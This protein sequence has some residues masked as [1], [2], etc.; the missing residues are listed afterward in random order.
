MKTILLI[1]L[2]L[3]GIES[4][5][6]Q[7]ELLGENTWYLQKLIIE[8]T[9]YDPPLNDESSI[10]PFTLEFD[11]HELSMYVSFCKN[12]MNF[13]DL[14]FLEHNQFTVFNDVSLPMEYCFNVE[15]R[16][17]SSFHN[18]FFRDNA[19]FSFTYT[20][21]GSSQGVRRLVITDN[22]RN[23]A[24]YSNQ[25]LS[26]SQFEKAAFKIYPNP[27]SD[28]LNLEWDSSEQISPS[29]IEIYDSLGKLC[30]KQQIASDKKSVELKHFTTGLYIV[31]LLNREG[32]IL[33]SEKILVQP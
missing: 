16:Q 18:E 17:F 26:S 23:Q 5:Q 1:I 15:N 20:L 8:D 13:K 32:K 6:A 2:L 19:L 7:P 10:Y 31:N 33:T 25:R 21:V 3:L 27:V 24:I 22:N 4:V 12:G 28:V 9:E 29:Y 14:V 30:F 11:L